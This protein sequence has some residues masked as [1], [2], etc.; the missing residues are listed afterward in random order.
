VRNKVPCDCK[1]CD[2][3]LVDERTRNKHAELE[4]D[5]ASSI[6]GFIPSLHF[7]RD[8]SSTTNIGYNTVAKESTRKIRTTEQESRLPE[9][10]NYYELTSDF[11]QHLPLKKWRRQDSFQE[12]KALLEISDD[13]SSIGHI[14]EDEDKEKDDEEENED[15]DNEEEDDDEHEEDDDKENEEDDD[16]E[17]EEDDDEEEDDDDNNDYSDEKEED[18]D[19]DSNDDNNEEGEDDDNYEQFDT[20]NDYADSWVVLWILKYQSRFRLSDVAV[21]VLIKFFWQLLQDINYER[22]K[23]FPSSLYIAKKLL[24]ASKLLNYAVCQSCD[25]LYDATEVITEDGFKC[26]HIE[27]PN[28]PMRTKRKPCGAELTVRV[29]IVKGYKRRPKLLFPC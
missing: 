10:D 13:F 9:N 23:E 25:T 18:Y 2:G 3:K 29:P 24:K 17:N 26:R 14:D 28:H 5:L 27:F 21:N 16:E 7:S 6:T 15:D 20:P 12:V 4:R 1:T 22:F 11:D 8:S 19:D